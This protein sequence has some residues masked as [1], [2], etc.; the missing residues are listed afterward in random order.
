M[1]LEVWQRR[2][3]PR[4]L[5]TSA[6]RLRNLS[7]LGSPSITLALSTR[8]LRLPTCAHTAITKSEGSAHD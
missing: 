3:T 4:S 7:L 2:T 6:R 5:A 8:R 1:R